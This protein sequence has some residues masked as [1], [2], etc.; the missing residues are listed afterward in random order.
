MGKPLISDD[1]KDYVISEGYT[2]AQTDKIYVVRTERWK[3]M[4]TIKGN[5]AVL[6]NSEK[7]PKE[8]KNVINEAEAKAREFEAV[9]NKHISWEKK[10]RMQRALIYEK[11]LIRMKLRKLRDAKISAQ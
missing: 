7:D 2:Y 11:E 5:Q 6:Y 10:I 8:T 3:Y 9:I 1:K 4:R